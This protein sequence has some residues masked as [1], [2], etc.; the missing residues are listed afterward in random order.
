MT[1]REAAKLACLERLL[2]ARVEQGLPRRVE[3]P[4][5]LARIA[6]LMWPRPVARPDDG[7][8]GQP[9]EARAHAHA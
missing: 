7:A 9:K 1:E 6:D 8:P 5:V 3:D 4:V 2:D